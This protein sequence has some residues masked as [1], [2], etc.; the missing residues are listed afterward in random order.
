M[1]EKEGGPAGHDVAADRRPYQRRNRGAQQDQGL[2]RK[3]T[4][5][6]RDQQECFYELRS[7]GSQMKGRG[8]ADRM[9]DDRYRPDRQGLEKALNPERLAERPPFRWWQRGTQAV[10]GT[11][12]GDQPVFAVFEREQHLLRQTA[13]AMQ[14]NNRA[15]VWRTA[16]KNMNL[17]VIDDA[18]RP[19][20]GL[21]GVLLQ[22]AQQTRQAGKS[23]GGESASD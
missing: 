15:S 20:S 5:A 18:D 23:S 4:A 10:A 19:E 12:D 22:H 9:G 13:A 3:R 6:R 1:P 17:S 8:T 2:R 21:G 11:I 14:N 16:F 7:A